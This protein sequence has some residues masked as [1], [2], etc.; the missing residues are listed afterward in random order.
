MTAAELIAALQNV[1]PDT[2][3]TIATAAGSVSIEAVRH[4][5][6][7]DGKFTIIAEDAETQ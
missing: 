2:P 3:V 5:G 6:Y 7:H 4:M 1:A